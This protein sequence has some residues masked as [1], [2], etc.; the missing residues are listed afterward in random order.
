M[1]DKQINL[2]IN[3]V[4]KDK[5]FRDGVK[6]IG[7]ATG[8][9]AKKSEGLLSKIRLGWIAVAG[10][11]YGAIRAIKS[12]INVA[13]DF[14][15]AVANVASVSGGATEEI[16]KLARA[17]GKEGLGFSAKEAADA[18]YFLASA[19][20]AVDDQ[21]KVLVPTL[22]LAAATQITLA[23]ATNTVVNQLKV[24]GGDMDNAE[25]FTDIMAKTVA[26]A[27]TNMQ[28]LGDALNYS[29]SVASL[30][31]VSFADLNA[32]IAA[33]ADLG[34]KGGKAGVQLRMAFVRLLKPTSRAA[35]ILKNKYNI[36]VEDLQQMLREG[37]VVDALKMLKNANIDVAD[38]LELF[39][40]RQS[41]FIKLVSD[42]IPIIEKLRKKIAEA[43]GT[44]QTMADK[45][46]DTLH[47][48]TKILSASW[49]EMILTLSGEGGLLPAL[50]TFVG[51][52]ITAVTETTEFV[53]LLFNIRVI[54]DTFRIV[55]ASFNVV[56]TMAIK[57]VFDNIK[58]GLEQLLEGFKGVGSVM[59]AVWERRFD[60]IGGIVKITLG[61][62][63]ENFTEFDEMRKAKTQEALNNFTT[64]W[65]KAYEKIT[66]DAEAGTA[67][68]IQ[69]MEEQVIAWEDA[70]KKINKISEDGYKFR[71]DLAET[72]VE[73]FLDGIEDMKSGSKSILIS[74]LKQFTTMIAGKLAVKAA[75]Y[76]AF[77][78]TIPLGVM[79]LAGAAAVKLA[80]SVA[81]GKI[82]SLA[83][84]A[85]AI[86]KDMMAQLHQGE[87]VLPA[88][89]NMPGL[90][91]EAFA[92]AAAVGL[93]AMRGGGGD[94]NRSYGGDT[95]TVTN[96][97]NVPEGSV[98]I[99][100]ILEYANRTGGRILRR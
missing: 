44:A 27:N 61:N 20:L 65:N 95:N 92:G 32:M 12:F 78:P 99:E 33:M 83:I 80:G 19:G 14:E 22:R 71:K 34:I 74:M 55:G 97:F 90:S 9:A 53:K 28:Q 24:Y 84:G 7:T 82:E 15:Q 42:G 69:L 72:F 49:K 75:E 56:W 48:K 31:G 4:L 1:A 60:E 39:G 37:R 21:A 6:R 100:E 88:G 68:Q 10:A 40:V 36:A 2:V 26:S 30:A 79:A 89:L 23:D 81:V 85:A 86:R 16:E 77:P 38:S 59:K 3:A 50:K 11:V 45:Q 66:K 70:Q 51:W 47:G 63:E 46:L 41:T 43:G 57:P 35:E 76:F 13:A 94:D 54:G 8:Q 87:R 18:M 98:G 96:T 73:G 91:N 17:A 58:I 52:I 5:R 93:S 62:M 64:V 25:M 67:E 29:S